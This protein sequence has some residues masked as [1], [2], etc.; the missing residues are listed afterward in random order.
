VSIV[1]D[2]MV[3]V[4][5]KRP[6]TFHQESKPSRAVREE[7]IFESTLSQEQLQMLEQENQSLLEGFQGTM[8]QIKYD[9]ILGSRKLTARGT[10]KTLLEISALQN[11]LMVQL[12]SQASLTD[13]LYDDAIEM[14]ESVEKGNKQLIRA[15]KRHKS[16]TRYILVF[17]LV[18]SLLLLLLDAWY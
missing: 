16:A 17:L 14:T 5:E 6:T 1:D 3:H 11:E 9:P 7:E 10:E 4:S 18:M 8:E 13:R 15:R 12:T 2:S